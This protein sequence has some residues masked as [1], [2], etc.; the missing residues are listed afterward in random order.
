MNVFMSKDSVFL[1]D[2]RVGMAWISQP[3]AITAEAII[4]FAKELFP[5]TA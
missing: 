5:R 3:V 4:A 2:L 1:N